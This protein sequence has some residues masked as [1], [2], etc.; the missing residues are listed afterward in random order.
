MRA[1]DGTSTSEDDKDLAMIPTPVHDLSSPAPAGQAKG[2]A[3]LSLDQ[4]LGRGR[5]YDAYRAHLSLRPS[6]PSG[7]DVTDIVN[8]FGA[9]EEAEGDPERLAVV[10]KLIDFDTFPRTGSNALTNIDLPRAI[11]GVWNEIH[12]LSGILAPL[13]GIAVPRLYGVW[14]APKGDKSGQWTRKTE[15]AVVVVMEDCGKQAFGT[16]APS[17]D[18]R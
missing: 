2:S 5:L 12:L 11:K 18:I 9:K 13:Q 4:Y 7:N 1:V 8:A 10:A 3:L 15:G 16:A 6:L 14:L 17:K